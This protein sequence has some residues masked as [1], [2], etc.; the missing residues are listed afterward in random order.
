[1]KFT[2]SINVSFIKF[3][4]LLTCFFLFLYSIN[5]RIIIAYTFQRNFKFIYLPNHFISNYFHKNYFCNFYAELISFRILFFISKYSINEQL[6]TSDLHICVF[7]SSAL[8]VFDG[9]I[10]VIS[11]SYFLFTF[12]F[13]ITR[14][15]KHHTLTKRLINISSSLIF[16]RLQQLFVKVIFYSPLI[17]V[18][19]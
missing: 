19:A 7:N 4:K 5:N 15:L 16:L 2:R 1:M 6:K 17:A 12:I 14:K 3:N 9:F 11:F 13:G 18:Y 10:I 8:N